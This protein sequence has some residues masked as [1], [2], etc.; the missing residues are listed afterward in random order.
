[1]QAKAGDMLRV[2]VG[3]GGAGC[4]GG[5]GGDGGFNG[6]GSGGGGDYGAGGGGGASEVWRMGLG[7][8]RVDNSGRTTAENGEDD[9]L[10]V[11][12]GGGGGGG[13]TDYCCAHG[14]AGGGKKAMSGVA[15][16]MTTPRTND[17][18]QGTGVLRREFTSTVASEQ[19]PPRMDPRDE[20]GLPAFHQHTDAGLAPDAD[21]QVLALPGGG[22]ES[23]VDIKSGS[24][25]S[26]GSW[27]YR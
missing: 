8:K 5:T 25:G 12:A 4:D 20:T 19:T 11:V 24:P 22:G 1:M 13:T 10:L 26:S 9:V 17:P 7:S 14:G 18:T 2:R 3:G 15:P 23:S 16:T 21:L 6:G 27:A